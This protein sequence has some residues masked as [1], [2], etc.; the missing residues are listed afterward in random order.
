M[1]DCNTRR[2][3]APGPPLLSRYFRPAL[4]V[5][6]VAAFVGG[7]VAVERVTISR[8]LRDDAI[9]TA[10]GW[11]R[12]LASNIP[13]LSVIA[14][15][16]TASAETLQF[17]S[18][19]K[20]VG[21]IFLFRIYDAEGRAIFVSDD[22]PEEETDT[23]DL[24]KHNPEALEA[25][26]AGVPMAEI[27]TG[28]PPSR[29]AFYAE[30]YI[31]RFNSAGKIEAVVETYVDQTSK[32]A[33]FEG[34][35]LR[36]STALGLLIAAAFG[37][38][39]IGWY[40]RK[41]DHEHSEA[42]VEYLA[43]FDA[44]SGLANRASLTDKLTRALADATAAGRPLAVHCIDIDRF[45]DINDRLGL[46]AGDQVIKIAAE[47]LQALSAPGDIVARL[48]G[49]EFA[50]VQV[51]PRDRADVEV[52]ARKVAGAMSVPAIV[53]GNEVPMSVGVG[54]SLAPEHGKDAERLI[55]SAELALAKGKSE[56]RARIRFFTLDLDEEMH[57]RLRLENAIETALATG[58]FMLH[59]QPLY[60]E[61]SETLVGFEALARLPAGDGTF[62]PPVEF[63]P[64]A[65]RIGAIGRL[66]AWVLQEAC[67]TA[68]N[69]P[70]H[71]TVSVNLSPAQF[72]KESIADVVAAV[73]ARSGLRPSRLL[74]EIT[75]SLLLR[76]SQGVM[77]ELAKLKKLGAEIVM[78][79][80][81]TGYSS[82]SYL[83]RF[84]FDKIKIDGSFM[85]AFDTPDA[86]AEKIVRTI[87]ALGH[88]LG[89]RVCI[90]GVETERHAEYARRLGCDEVQGFQFGRPQEATDVAA[91]IMADVRRSVPRLEEP[92]ARIV[93]L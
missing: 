20:T 19:V 8:L 83:W 49:D 76:D 35:F 70:D 2:P 86:P 25:I 82:L 89:M 41:R 53:N 6:S 90:E 18:K 13:D 42:R 44:L 33:E 68:A 28:E 9:S 91:T 37:I 92:A 4:L 63:I 62:I 30:A 73:L 88:T 34:T 3:Q 55:K 22:L 36:S 21:G 78:D 29:P 27:R 11:A 85:R 16:G 59:Y 48:A 43:N 17:L 81:G 64:A 79:D 66:G 84:P 51:L 67:S 69:W 60:S 38:P 7:A 61:P 12:F 56:G 57:E 58:G 75:E 52:F 15:G 72:G 80:F 39:G 26:E 87:T 47:R 77:A 10:N 50:V 93:G 32:R 65:E 5:L 23:A 14:A 1:I 24:G 31:P 74:L 45:K 40:L 54:V 46:G 71:L